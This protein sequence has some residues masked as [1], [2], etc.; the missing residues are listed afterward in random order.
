MHIELMGRGLSQAGVDRA[1]DWVAPEKPEHE[2]LLLMEL[3][4]HT[5]D[6]FLDIENADW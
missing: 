1:T 6:A 5:T 4:E 3:Y 2:C